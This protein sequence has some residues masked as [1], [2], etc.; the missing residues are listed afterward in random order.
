[1]IPPAT[2]KK[3]RKIQRR[4]DEWA[5][6]DVTLRELY[7]AYTKRRNSKEKDFF[8]IDATTP[9]NQMKEKVLKT[10]NTIFE[11]ENNRY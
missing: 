2:T 3:R 9:E 8:V 1:L 6:Q 10:I 4:I 7:K 5:I 11:L